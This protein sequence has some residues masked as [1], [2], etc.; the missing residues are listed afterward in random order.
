MTT[1][2]ARYVKVGTGANV[3]P[4]PGGLGM[5]A[6]SAVVVRIALS[7][8]DADGV[9]HADLQT[10]PVGSVLQIRNSAG[11]LWSVVV[12]PTQPVALDYWYDITGDVADT[13][14]L[15]ASTGN[16]IL[17]L[18]ATDE[19]PLGLWVTG[20]QI[21][22]HVRV[23]APTAA[24]LQWADACALAVSSGIDRYLGTQPEPLPD[25]GMYEEVSANALTAGGDA[26][27]RRDAPFGLSSYSDISGIATRVASDY[28]TGI[29]AQLDRWRTVA[30]GI[31]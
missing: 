1:A 10:A 25:N 31:A 15:V 9:A 21:L 5:S 20:T 18:P 29:H 14:G 4:A 27:R 23:T 8:I 22:E 3:Q 30:D 13:A 19:N 12:Q 2:P 17:N 16:L 24:D 11:V 7:K 6:L 26:Y 28:L